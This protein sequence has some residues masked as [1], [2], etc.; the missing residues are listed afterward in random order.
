MGYEKTFFTKKT[1]LVCWFVF[2]MEGG[3]PKPCFLQGVFRI[4]GIK[5]SF[6][7]ILDPPEPKTLH[8][9]RFFKILQ[10][11]FLSFRN[12]ENS[13]DASQDSSRWPQVRSS[14]FQIVQIIHTQSHTHTLKRFV[15][16]NQ[17]S[18]SKNQKAKT[19]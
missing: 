10:G 18:K 15:H 5:K 1:K 12:Y 17:T 11:S 7:C 9:T 13:S 6:G 3:T 14:W 2:G 19:W 4:L 8:F 16:V